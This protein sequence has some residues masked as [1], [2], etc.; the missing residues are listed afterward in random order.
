MIDDD[1][2]S[3]IVSRHDSQ[4]RHDTKERDRSLN[5]LR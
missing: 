3:K 5:G 1:E 2:L 4:G